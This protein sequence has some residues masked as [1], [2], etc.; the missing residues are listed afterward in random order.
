MP[1]NRR[2]AESDDMPRLLH[3]PAEIDVV[4]GLMIFVIETADAFERPAIKG[5]VTPWN[6][7]GHGVG[8][9]DMAWP[10][11]CGR[12]TGLDPISCRRRDIR[13]THSRKVS[14]D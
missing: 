4:A 6:V 13:A 3:S 10:A 8:K 7:L 14:A 11:W 9:Q 2:R 1:D 5:H 12:H